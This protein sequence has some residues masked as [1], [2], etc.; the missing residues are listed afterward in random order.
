MS[1]A[2]RLW[3]EIQIHDY[4]QHSD[5]NQHTC[6]N[7]NFKYQWPQFSDQKTQVD[8][9]DQET[10]SVGWST[11][12]TA[13]KIKTALKNKQTCSNQMEPGSKQALLS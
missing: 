13:F 4:Q 3:K 2:N 8:C 11:K 6:F 9:V 1:T 12:N 10:K 7:N 5:H